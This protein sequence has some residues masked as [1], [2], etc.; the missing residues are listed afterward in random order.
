MVKRWWYTVSIAAF[1]TVDLGT[2]PG[3]R[4]LNYQL[5]PL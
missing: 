5:L 1:Q 2:I 4:I 3:H